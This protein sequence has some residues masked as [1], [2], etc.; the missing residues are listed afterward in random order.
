[1][2][3]IT[4]NINM[5]WGNKKRFLCYMARINRRH[6]YIY[7]PKH[8]AASKCHMNQQR[9]NICSTKQKQED[10]ILKSVG[11]SKTSK[12]NPPPITHEHFYVIEETDHPWF[13]CLLLAWLLYI[14][15]C[16]CL[17]YPRKLLNLS[18][19]G[20]WIFGLGDI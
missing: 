20:S 13:W 19:L 6:S 18:Y 3:T 17:L 2:I 15:C 8:V 1:M 11:D 12:N 9:Q 5:D 14:Y 10:P 7:L 16:R 4:G